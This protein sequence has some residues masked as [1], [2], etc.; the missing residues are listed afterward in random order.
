MKKVLLISGKA[1]FPVL[2]GSFPASAYTQHLQVVSQECSGDQPPPPGPDKHSRKQASHRESRNW[3]SLFLIPVQNECRPEKRNEHTLPAHASSCRPLPAQRFLG[4]KSF[5]NEKPVEQTHQLAGSP[6][7]NAPEAHNHRRA[8][9]IHDRSGKSRNALSRSIV[10]RPLL[11]AD[12]TTR[13][14]RY[15]LFMISPMVNNTVFW[16]IRDLAERDPLKPVSQNA[17]RG[18]VD[19]P[20][21]SMSADFACSSRADSRRFAV[22]IPS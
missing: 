13:R 3:L 22:R 9:R 8:P 18:K 4:W 6:V 21:F 1:L 11:H 12:K 2:P 14:A 5:G 19:I 15:R 16:S 7:I 20:Y 10:P 17:M